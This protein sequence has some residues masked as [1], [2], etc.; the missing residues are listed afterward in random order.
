MPVRL[1]SCIPYLSNTGIKCFSGYFIIKSYKRIIPFIHQTP[2]LTSESINELFG[3]KLYFKCENFQKVG[4]FKYRGATNAVQLLPDDDLKNGVATHSSG[5]HAQALSLAAKVKGIKAF[6]V[7]PENSK[8]VKVDAVKAYG[9]EITFCEPTL[10]SREETLEKVV[11]KINATFIHPYH[12]FNIICGQGTAAFEFINE[13]KD[14][15]IIISPVGGGGLLSGTSIA[16]KSLNPKIKVIAAEPKNA[17]DAYRSFYAK[18][19]FPSINP[20]TIA[21][22]LLTSLGDMNFKI[23]LKYVDEIITAKED[24]IISAMKLI[25]ERM[26]IIIEPSAAVTLAI[27]IENKKKFRSQNI[28]LILSGGNVDFDHLPF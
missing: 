23:I 22:G 16:A 25:W 27:I 10:K 8:K 18:K 20:N 7:M 12:N 5:N 26:K 28:G 17:D 1:C 14:M 4:A 11:Q 3:C 15:N 13:V 21:D 2:V 9:G 6:I 24:S 19:L